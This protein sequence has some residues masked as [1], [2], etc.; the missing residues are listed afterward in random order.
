MP[1]YEDWPA[2]TDILEAI[3]MEHLRQEQLRTAQGITAP[4][5]AI[6]ERGECP[7]CQQLRRELEAARHTIHQL[8][9][10]ISVDGY[11]TD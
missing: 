2:L 5:P 4:P 1:W 6:A 3:E 7:H 9:Q 8:R 11:A 10:P